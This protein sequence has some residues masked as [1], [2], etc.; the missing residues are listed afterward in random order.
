MLFLWCS[1]IT[2]ETWVILS[3]R[4]EKT[5]VFSKSRCE[6]PLTE[7]CSCMVPF[8]SSEDC[9]FRWGILFPC[10]CILHNWNPQRLLMLHQKEDHKAWALWMKMNYTHS[11]VMLWWVC[12]PS[13]SPL[14]CGATTINMLLS[15]LMFTV[16][17]LHQLKQEIHILYLYSI[18]SISTSI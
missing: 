3:W 11:A 2:E 17:T 7:S 14:P 8:G 5:G 13:A 10:E 16:A 12:A 1:W 6:V 15:L 4:T 18:Y 9:M